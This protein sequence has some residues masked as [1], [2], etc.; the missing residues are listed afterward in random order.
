VA[1]DLAQPGYV[2]WHVKVRWIPSKQQFW[3]VYSAF[4]QGQLGCD[5]DDLFFARSADGVH[6][7]TFA[8]PLLRH[9]DRDWT[10]AA[11]Y[12]SSFLYLPEN[13]EL[14]VW[15]SARSTEGKWTLGLARFRY[16]RQLQELESGSLAG[17]RSVPT[18]QLR[19]LTPLGEAP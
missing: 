17:P 11:V 4:P 3:A 6:W 18:L 12:R 19:S 7:Q 14:K 5:I 15:V 1:T 9:E 16:S 10:G 13:D 8:Q 2:I